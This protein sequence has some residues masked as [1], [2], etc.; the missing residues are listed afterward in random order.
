MQPQDFLSRRGCIGG[1]GL[2]LVAGVVPAAWAATGVVRTSRQMMGTRIEVV[3]QGAQAALAVSRA[4]AEMARLEGLMSRYRSDSDIAALQAAAGQRPVSVA[5]ETMAVLQTAQALSR[6]SSG[7]FDITVGAYGWSFEPGRPRLPEARELQ[8]QSTRVGHRRVQLDPLAGQAML[9]QAGMKLDL[10]GVAKLPILSAGMQVLRQ[11]SLEGAM[12]NG[13]GDVLVTG[14]LQGRDWRIGLRNPV[15]PE[16][17]LGTVSLSEGVV[18]SSGD[19]ERCFAYKGTR[20]H[21]MLDPRTGWPVQGVRGVAMM[22]DEIGPLNGR[23]AMA[24]L[25]GA[26][27]ARQMLGSLPGVHSLLVDAQGQLWQHAPGAPD[28]GAGDAHQAWLNPVA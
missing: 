8:Q 6:Q 18:A 27:A 20:Y 13:G 21:H 25:L 10:G 1:L 12:I 7:R 15:K 17:L 19:Y 16:Q 22:A 23:G 4:L 5:P 26:P 9:L 14:H 28:P 11:H 24:M 3:A 2:L